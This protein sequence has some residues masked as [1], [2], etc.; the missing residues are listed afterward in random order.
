MLKPGMAVLN[1]EDQYCNQTKIRWQNV[2]GL[3][4]YCADC[5]HQDES[6]NGNP[7]CYK[8]MKEIPKDN[9]DEGFIPDWCPL[10]KED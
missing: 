9:Y 8:I 2:S 7:M 5:S 6:I 10:P 1:V 4:E 3:V